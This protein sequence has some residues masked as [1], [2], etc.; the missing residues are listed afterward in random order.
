[1]PRTFIPV[2]CALALAGCQ[3]V[4]SLPTVR[5]EAPSLAGKGTLLVNVLWPKRATQMIPLS[6]QTIR[7]R[8]TKGNNILS[9]I[10]LSRPVRNGSPLVA[11]A[12]LRLDADSGLT[13]QADAFSTSLV[14]SS[15]LPIAS[16]TLTGVS[17]VAN[18]RTPVQLS[19][20]P[21]F[22]PTLTDFTP[23]N[24]GPGVPV[25]LRGSFGSSGYYGLGIGG[26]EGYGSLSGSDVIAFIPSG[27]TTGPLVVLADGVPS[28]MGATFNVL[29]RL[30]L[31]P[32]SPVTSTGSPITFTV[33][34][35][36]DTSSQSIANPTLT[37]WEVVDPANLNPPGP[38]PSTVGTI[39]SSGVFTPQA[40]G[41]AWVRVRSGYLFATASVTVR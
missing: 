20:A 21:V 32:L 30:D 40:T 26:V 15:D 34:T 27:A 11:Q 6:T 14:A 23:K 39:S 37:A 10:P 3:S 19:L 8:V 33:P 36:L 24:G 5:A 28:S 35:G 7:F 1:M 4:T 9:E 13:I 2:L 25:T 22:T 29:T 38:Q 12:S 31:S 18:Q 17:V 16:A 41:T